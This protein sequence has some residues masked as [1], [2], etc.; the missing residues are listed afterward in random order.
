MEWMMRSGAAG[1]VVAAVL[2]LAGCGTGD[3][4]A[5]QGPTTDPTPQQ[6]ISPTALAV[7]SLLLAEGVP[8]APPGTVVDSTGPV[9]VTGVIGEPSRQVM[10]CTPL[11]L[12][13]SD[14]PGPAEP[15]ATGAASSSSVIG[16]AQVDQYAVVYAD[17]AAAQR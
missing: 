8:P 5:E 2:V 6:T 11:E 1:W 13:E 12:P 14:D 4:S 16:A 7:G 10:T 3:G 9:A 17:D 15:D